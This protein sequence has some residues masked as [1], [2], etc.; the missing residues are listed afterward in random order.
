MNITLSKN[1][2]LAFVFFMI[3][4]FIGFF[5]PKGYL[6]LFFSI[7]V[8]IY[9]GRIVQKK[10]SVH[11]MFFLGFS[12]FIFLPAVLNWYYLDVE[13]SFYFVTSFVS[14][15][16]LYLTRKT[17]VNPFV[18]YGFQPRFIF[19]IISILM[20]L[21]IFLKLEVLIVPLFAFVIFLLSLCFKQNNIKNNSF[22]LFIFSLV[23]FSYAFLSWSGYGRTV[24]IGWLL[25][26]TLQ[27]AYSI[28]FKINKY[29]F[30]LIPGLAATL[31]SDRS[32]LEL[33]FSGFESALY[34]SAYQPYRLA[35]SFIDQFNINNF[36]FSGFFDQI[37]FTFFV[38]IPRDFWLSK[39]KGFGFEYT[40]RNFDQ[41]LIDAGHSIASTLIGDHIYFL[42]YLGIISS[43]VI[44]SLIAYAINFFYRIKGLNGNGV[45][46]FSSS[47]MVLV[48]G[49]MTSF[50]ARIALPS[51]VFIIIIVFFRR[52]LIGETKIKLRYK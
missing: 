5:N 39:P 16:F 29:I 47:M 33:K 17:L 14:A 41:S 18:D 28:D 24:V 23:F 38:F 3:I 31:L 21:L 20:I 37:L 27:F 10:S 52:V 26:A 45:I 19:I 9:I 42:G 15:I 1:D 40:V 22:Y 7:L 44:L 12:S 43:I 13:F 32:L 11:M 50:S 48:W 2:S 30:G 34:D 51:I 46:V 36:D 25:L 49:G 4:I 35:S 8:Y 6:S